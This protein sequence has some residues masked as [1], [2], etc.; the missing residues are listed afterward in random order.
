[1]IG[2][3]FFVKGCRLNRILSSQRPRLLQVLQVSAALFLLPCLPQGR[4]VASPLSSVLL[5]LF[6][7]TCLQGSHAGNAQGFKI[8]ALL[9]L[10]DTRANKPR[11]NLMHYIVQVYFIYCSFLI[12]LNEKWE[13]AVHSSSA[14]ELIFVSHLVSI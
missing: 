4:L 1:M 6:Y 5:A 13:C 12:D 9:K 7:S 14:F 3:W 10:T 2:Y 8:N 11:M